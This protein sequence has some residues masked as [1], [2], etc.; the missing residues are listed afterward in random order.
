M[1]YLV[2]ARM[3]PEAQGR[4]REAIRRGAVPGAPSYFADQLAECFAQG[5]RQDDGAVLW[6][7]T[8][9]CERYFG[10]ALAEEQ[11]YIACYF[12]LGQ[13]KKVVAP[14]KCGDMSGRRPFECGGCEC[15][16]PVRRRLR[17]PRLRDLL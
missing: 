9:H 13:V 6:V 8:C 10:E 11:K 17:G 12:E 4:V 1:K 15:D 3:K 14:R 16:L 5:R 7:E 2:R